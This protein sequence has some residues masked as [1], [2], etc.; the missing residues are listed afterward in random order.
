MDGQYI[1]NINIINRTGKGGGSKSGKRRK[2]EKILDIFRKIRRKCRKLVILKMR[3]K[4]KIRRN[5]NEKN[6][7]RKEIGK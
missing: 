2:R 1:W 7:R 4:E 3:K 5:W 6:P